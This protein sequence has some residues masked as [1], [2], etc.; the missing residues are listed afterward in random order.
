MASRV[1]GLSLR[2]LNT[3]WQLTHGHPLLLAETF[4]DPARFN[5]TCYRAAN[6]QCLGETRGDARHAGQYHHHGH[7]KTVWVY[8]L[9][10]RARDW[11]RHTPTG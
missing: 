8:P 5:G 3:D 7:P 11:L 4:V 6:W 2:R 9:H 10:R 1:L